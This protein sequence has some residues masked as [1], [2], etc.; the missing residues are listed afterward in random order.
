MDAYIMRNANA[1]AV[2]SSCLMA[3]YQSATAGGPLRACA[4]VAARFQHEEQA[5]QGL[6]EKILLFTADIDALSDIRRTLYDE[7]EFSRFLVG[8][9]VQPTDTHA[10]FI[11]QIISGFMT[12][13]IF[14]ND[15]SV[16]A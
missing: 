6:P 2:N 5:A 8:E 15:A 14:N 9:Y 4:A 16:L 1:L 7:A 12:D 13:Q 11:N 3:L 10:D